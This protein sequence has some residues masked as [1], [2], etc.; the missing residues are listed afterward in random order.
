M[1]T[2]EVLVGA[3]EV[4]VRYCKGYTPRWGSGAG[5][6]P[7]GRAA[8]RGG[9]TGGARC[10]WPCNAGMGWVAC[11]LAQL[12]ARWLAC[13]NTQSVFQPEADPC[14]L[15]NALGQ[16]HVAPA[17]SGRLRR[18]RAGGPLRRQPAALFLWAEATSTTACPGA[19]PSSAALKPPHDALPSRT[20]ARCPVQSSL[21]AFSATRH[22]LPR[23]ALGGSACRP[24]VFFAV[25]L[26]AM[27]A[28]QTQAFFP[29][30]AKGKSAVQVR[31]VFV[32]S[33]KF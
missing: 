5:G 3:D 23:V 2:G 1:G 9:G 32:T 31:K 13:A 30:V 24:A 18:R 15:L 16:M 20:H 10:A 8:G 22:Q 28:A 4:L 33:K 27:G 25:F 29:D 7:Q 14:R 19:L 17:A 12:L 26:A 6:A 11:L 21:T